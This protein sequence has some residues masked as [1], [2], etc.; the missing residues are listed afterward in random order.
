MWTATFTDPSAIQVLE[1][2]GEH[3]TWHVLTI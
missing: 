2:A 1:I 3:S